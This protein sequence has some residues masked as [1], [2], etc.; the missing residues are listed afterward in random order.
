[1][2]ESQNA[3]GRWRARIIIA[4]ER[5]AEEVEHH[6]VVFAFD[7]VPADLRDA[8]A[9]LEVADDL[10]LIEELRVAA[11]YG[12]E[13]DGNLLPGADVHAWLKSRCEI[14]KT[15]SGHMV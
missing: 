8:H 7:A 9:A 12:L 3:R 2:R 13:L 15:G 14:A 10:G 1:M 11:P 5:W 4:L 6:D